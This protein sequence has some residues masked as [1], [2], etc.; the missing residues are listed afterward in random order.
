MQAR[1]G[2]DSSKIINADIN[3]ADF[4]AWEAELDFDGDMIAAEGNR[5]ESLVLA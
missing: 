1:H 3:S 5:S 4:A 2:L